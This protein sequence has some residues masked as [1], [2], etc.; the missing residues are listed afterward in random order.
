[1][2]GKLENDSEE[3]ESENRP[4]NEVLAVVAL[5]PVGRDNIQSAWCSGTVDT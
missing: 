5:P 4:V 2:K 3:I 1:M